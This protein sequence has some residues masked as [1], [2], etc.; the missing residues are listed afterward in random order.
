MKNGTSR[1]RLAGATETVHESGM[2]FLGWVLIIATMPGASIKEAP[3]IV[4]VDSLPLTDLV[5]LIGNEA[6]R[7]SMNRRSSLCARRIDQTEDLP[8]LLID[9]VVLVVD[10]VSTL[11]L[12]VPGVGP[13]DV[14]GGHAA[15]HVMHVHVERH[16]CSSR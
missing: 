6:V 13:S 3:G 11:D 8:G 15:I 7:F 16:G 1:S 4:T 9:P 5:D 10:A 12:D 14:L 2:T